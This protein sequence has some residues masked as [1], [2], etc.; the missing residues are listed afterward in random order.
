M[1]LDI[2]AFGPHPDDVEIGAGGILAHHA[3]IGYRCGIIDLT[4]G[5]LASNGTVEERK[6]EASRAAEIL[7]CSLRECLELPDAQ[8]E[9]NT[10]AISRVVKALRCF[11]P[12]IVLAPYYWDDRHPDHSTAGELVK[13]AAYLSGLKRYP[14]EG[15]PYRP[16]KTY[17][18]LLSVERQPDL[19]VDV[20]AVYEIKE[21]AIR[22]HQTQFFHS[23]QEQALTL[24]NDP[25]FLRFVRSRDSYFGSLIGSSW[26]EG[27]VSGAAMSVSDLVKSF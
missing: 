17:Y 9:V 21:R 23:R 4:A 10:Q 2:L 25:F 12:K 24:V 18:Y 3:A 16:Q 15:T 6:E 14:V 1:E 13:R 5:E 26:G 27:I 22:A 11:R 20:S 8:L 7:Q 19:V